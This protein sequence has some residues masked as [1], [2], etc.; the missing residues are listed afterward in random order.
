MFKIFG[1]CAI[2]MQDY[3]SSLIAHLYLKDYLISGN[4]RLVYEIM[5]SPY[6]FYVLHSNSLL[7]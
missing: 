7:L 1:A 2:G 6:G 4:I 3:E 5:T